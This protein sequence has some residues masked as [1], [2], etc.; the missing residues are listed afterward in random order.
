MIERAAPSD[1][2]NIPFRR[3]EK[4]EAVKE[5]VEQTET[6]M[7]SLN[8]EVGSVIDQEKFKQCGQDHLSHSVI[9]SDM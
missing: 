2:A 3:N 8:S 4:G 6:N 7:P 9:L 5:K 1:I